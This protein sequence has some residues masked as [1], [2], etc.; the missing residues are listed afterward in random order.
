MCTVMAWSVLPTRWQ[1]TMTYMPFRSAALGRTC[2]QT[3]ARLGMLGGPKQPHFV[4]IAQGTHR[5][6]D[7]PRELTGAVETAPHGGTSLLL[8]S[9]WG[10]VTSWS[11]PLHADLRLPAEKD[12]E[13][14]EVPE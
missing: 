9:V 12:G 13:C 8:W 3:V 7:L 14:A 11:S 1:V 4:V 10:D 6:R 5:H 2:V